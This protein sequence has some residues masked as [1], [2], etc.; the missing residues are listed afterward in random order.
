MGNGNVTDWAEK[1]SNPLQVGGIETAVLDNGA[2][3]GTRIAWV[4]TGAGLRYKVVIDRGL[5]IADAPY[6]ADRLAWISPFGVKIGRGS[7]REGVCED[8]ELQGE[9]ETL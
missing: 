6:N 3:R 4:N 1:I 9:S 7:F 8:G 2:G 5:D